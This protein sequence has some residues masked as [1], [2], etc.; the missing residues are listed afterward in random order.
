M[1]IAFW[2]GFIPLFSLR[3]HSFKVPG[4]STPFIYLQVNII[5]ER[6]DVQRV[7][8]ELRWLYENCQRVAREMGE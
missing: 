3:L 6:T 2:A 8:A 7:H 4:D 5:R 1:K